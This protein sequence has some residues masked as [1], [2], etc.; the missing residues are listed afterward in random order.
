MTNVTFIRSI[1]L[2]HAIFFPSGLYPRKVISHTTP[3][4]DVSE[5]DVDMQMSFLNA[6]PCAMR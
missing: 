1:P 2:A 6:A 3:D 4:F 5:I